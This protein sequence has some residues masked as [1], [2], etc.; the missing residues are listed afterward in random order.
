MLQRITVMKNFGTYSNYKP[1]KNFPE[2]DGTF[3]KNN[4]IYAHNGSGKTTFSL[5][6]QSL[7]SGS[8]EVLV[9]KKE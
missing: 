3:K 2:W 7:S 6:F 5:I 4:I 9:K 8:G 1:S